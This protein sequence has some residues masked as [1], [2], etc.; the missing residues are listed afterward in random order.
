[1]LVCVIAIY[2][3]AF[4]DNETRNSD[5][6]L[7]FFHIIILCFF[8]K[9]CILEMYIYSYS[10]VVLFYF[11]FI[12]L[13]KFSLFILLL[14]PVTYLDFFFYFTIYFFFYCFYHPFIW[15]ECT[16]IVNIVV[17]F[18]FS[19]LFQLHYCSLIIK[20]IRTITFFC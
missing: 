5:R 15:D 12:Y 13:F 4:F 9:L 6:S 17:I 1:M 8:L 20:T 14:N 7:S 2:F 18:A 19:F 3:F 11:F 10:F 16:F